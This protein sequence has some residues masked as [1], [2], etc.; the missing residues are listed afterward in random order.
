MGA[1]ADTLSTF[2]I[3]ALFPVML[4]I[5]EVCLSLPVSNAWPE[6]GA[7]VIK[8]LKSRMGKRG[9]KDDRL[10]ALM[11]VAINGPKLK[12]CSSVD[13]ATVQEWLKQKPRRKLVKMKTTTATGDH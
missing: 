5:A 7:L 8:C 11:Q 13:T 3:S 4:H 10:E 12:E 2:H 6:R 9:M 1:G